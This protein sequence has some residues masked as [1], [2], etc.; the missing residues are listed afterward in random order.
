MLDARCDD[1]SASDTDSLSSKMGKASVGGV[2]V[3]ACHMD[4]TN[5]VPKRRAQLNRSKFQAPLVFVGAFAC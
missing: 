1:A 5:G 2:Y 4:A 3:A